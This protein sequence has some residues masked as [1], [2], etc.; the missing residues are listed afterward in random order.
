MVL[1]SCIFAIVFFLWRCQLAAPADMIYDHVEM[2]NG[3]SLEGVYNFTLFRISKYNHTSYVFNG[4]VEIYYD[5]EEDGDLY[6]ELAFYYNRLNNNQYTKS[7]MRVRKDKVCTLLKTYYGFFIAA[8][9]DD[10][11]N[12]PRLGIGEKVCPLKKVNDYLF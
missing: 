9:R 4:E 2:I 10:Q 3:T 1:F 7:P 12:L 8:S 11:N 5:I 6:V